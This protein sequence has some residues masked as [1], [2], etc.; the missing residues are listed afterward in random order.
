M[1]CSMIGA[2]LV[3]LN[4]S[5]KCCCC[6]WNCTGTGVSLSGPESALDTRDFVKLSLTNGLRVLF[7]MP[8]HVMDI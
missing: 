8:R 5:H 1:A 2:N 6:A 3:S 4:I 7:A